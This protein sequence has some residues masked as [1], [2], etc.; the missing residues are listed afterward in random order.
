MID[1]KLP[2]D[3]STVE[4][5][6]PNVDNKVKSIRKT[7]QNHNDSLRKLL[8]LS[9]NQPSEFQLIDQSTDSSNQSD[10]DY[11]IG[12]R[13]FIKR[14][15]YSY[16]AL[17]KRGKLSVKINENFVHFK[18]L[19]IVKPKKQK[20]E[21]TFD[22]KLK[23]K[24]LK[25]TKEEDVNDFKVYTEG[26]MELIQ[27]N[28]FFKSQ[29]MPNDYFSKNRVPISEQDKKDILSDAKKL[30]ILDLDETLTHCET[31]ELNMK[32]CDKIISIKLNENKKKKIGLNIRP[33][34]DNFLSSLQ[35]KFVV[36]LFTAS[37]KQYAD[38]IVSEID[39]EHKYFKY[40]LCRHNCVSISFNKDNKNKIYYV[41]DLRVFDIPMEKIVIV[42]NSI[43]SFVYQINNGIPIL[44]FYS[45]DNDNELQNLL[46]Y[47]HFMS[48]VK[49]V[50]KEIQKSFGLSNKISA[51]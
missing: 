1:E 30:L 35:D 45:N 49:D 21:V 5:F 9:Q 41:K 38:S 27:N 2:F 15:V 34:L 7:P 44:P 26:C 22:Q 24:F 14:K 28:S 6:T 11:E 13:V 50:T 8:L 23:E 12:S 4:S 3:E 51:L 43:L 17:K 46:D 10:S 39:P 29:Q 19:S 36:V 33:G 18:K 40:I 48:Q 37:L 25:I 16:P 47:L 42:D 32:E 31:N 20:S